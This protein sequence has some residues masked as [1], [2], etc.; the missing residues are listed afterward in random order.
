MSFILFFIA[1]LLNGG[2]DMIKFNWNRFIFQT[3]WWLERGEWAPGLRTWLL[4]HVATMFAGGWHLL[5]F[6]MVMAVVG[7]VLIYSPLFVWWIDLTLMFGVFST[8]FI[9]G[10]Y[11]LWRKR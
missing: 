9:V 5:K 8:G 6:L 3:E 1:G 10:Y 2:M 11:F 4:K 7:T